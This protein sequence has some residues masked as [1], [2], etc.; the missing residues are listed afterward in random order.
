MTRSSI[1]YVPH[2]EA[3]YILSPK[4][5]IVARPR[6]VNDHIQ[7]LID[8]KKF[9]SALDVVKKHQNEH[10]NLK[11]K[12][13]DVGLL[14][15]NDLFQ[16]GI[17]PGTFAFLKHCSYAL[18][19]FDLAASACSNILEDR[20][21]LWEEWVFMF[22]EA[23]H[24]QVRVYQTQRFYVSSSDRTISLSRIIYLFATQPSTLQCTK[25]F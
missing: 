22:A 20:L 13:L 25:W 8:H 5:I 18:E 16:K 6:D 19:E 21:N 11:F 12:V 17:L 1:E 24:L 10:V 7:W 9:Q 4:D 23:G 2:E 15:L 14:Y 3:F